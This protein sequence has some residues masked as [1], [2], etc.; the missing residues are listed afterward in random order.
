[1]PLADAAVWYAQQGIPVFPLMPGR[2][3]PFGNKWLGVA[4]GVDGGFHVA[5]IDE[6]TIREW[7]RREPN[8]NIGAPTGHLF[9]VLDVD[10]KSDSE[11]GEI[12]ED[13]P[14]SIDALQSRH[15]ALPS[16]L[17]Q[18]T[19]GGGLQYLFRWNG[20]PIRNRARDI[21]RG[22][23][24]RGVLPDTKEPAGYTVLP[25]S[26]HPLTRKA[27]AWVANDAP[28][29]SAALASA[30]QW[31]IDLACREKDDRPKERANLEGGITVRAGVDTRYV[32]R[33]VDRELEELA[34]ASDGAQEETINRVALKLAGM[35][36]G[37][38]LSESQV[39]DHFFRA[40]HKIPNT[41]AR[42]PWTHRHF[43]Q[44]WSSGM[45]DATPR[46]VP[47]PSNDRSRGAAAT[48]PSRPQ[49]TPQALQ[50]DER[51]TG[52]PPRLVWVNGTQMP[53]LRDR[54][55]IAPDTG[56]PAEFPVEYLPPV[57]RGAVEALE[58]H[59]QAPRGLCA[60]SVLSAAALAAQGHANVKTRAMGA[61]PLSLFMLVVAASGERKTACD[62]MALLA[63][64]QQED[65][66]RAGY[67]DEMRRY[68]N[69]KA[70]Y[71]AE[72][73]KIE[74]N[75]KMGFAEKA[76]Q[77]DQLREPP[78]PL[79]PNLRLKEPTY[80][81][82]LRLLHEGQP[83]IGVFTSEGGQFLGGHGMTEEAKI[84]TITGLSEL[85]DSGSAQRVR[86]G[87]NTFMV[88]RRVS[89]S[90]AVQPMLAAKLLGDEIAQD[91]GFVGRFLVTMPE[92]RIGTRVIRESNPHGDVRLQEF[93]RSLRRLFEASLPL[94]DETRNELD[95]QNLELDDHAWTVWQSVAQNIEDECG[96][97]GRW[98]PV[99]AG[100]LKM[101]ENIARI[102]GI[103][104]LIEDPKAMRISG[105]IM[106]SAASIGLFY[107]QEALRL[108][109]HSALDPKTQELKDLEQWLT[110]TWRGDLIN[111]T[112]IQQRAPNGLRNK[113]VKTVRGW[114]SDLCAAGL[115]E[116]VGP[117]EIN[118]KPCKEAYRI[119][120]EGVS[121]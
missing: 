89:V 17:T 71:D 38:G 60:H 91:Q 24:T 40:C 4:E 22:L 13:G 37:W 97:S 53:S 15:G 64:S 120:R 26:I 77:L 121:A 93:K 106:A 86:V 74:K 31:L 33:A 110:G 6:A 34:C 102:S 27:Y 45:R 16:T 23:D 69:S 58:E 67:E 109:G 96:M 48:R 104:A 55:T 66:L 59:V 99:R 30:P 43:A 52:T 103:L 39:R 7:W 82:L 83:S 10:V 85:W 111:S 54:L 28:S 21:A 25:P 63:A 119:N 11:T 114:I 107:L 3:T 61:R 1:M 84:R 29:I 50:A 88:G 49:T 105:D 57:M 113:G 101:A 56:R 108:V 73:R 36:K 32:A 117:A 80:E 51:G 14:A 35:V 75:D 5:T 44:K 65:S 81:G 18:R 47:E 41:R 12:L 95:P 92:S 68:K 100:A 46:A 94:R 79:A 112:L 90:L 76:H 72:R 20:E 116:Y 70:A 62:E 115:L 9:W 118:G 8:A 98:R 78:K 42:D 87:E 19:G 2:K